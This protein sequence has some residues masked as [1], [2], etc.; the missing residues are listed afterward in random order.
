MTMSNLAR[1]VQIFSAPPATVTVSG[2]TLELREDQLAINVVSSGGQNVDVIHS[3][4]REGTQMLIR[5]TD[6]TNTVTLRDNQAGTNLSLGSTTRVLGAGDMIV[7]RYSGTKWEEVTFSA[8]AGNEDLFLNDSGSLT[9]GT[10]SDV[11]MAW[12]GTDFDITAAAD[13]SIIKLGTGT[14]S[15]DLWL[16]GNIA[17]S[18]LLWDASQNTVS[19]NGPVR[20]NGFNAL[21]RRF[22]LKW[23]AGQ[24]GKPGIN[25]DIQSATEAT[26]MI[27]DPDFEVLG[28]NASS[29]DVTF[30]AEGGIKVE[31]DGADGDEVIIAPHL[32][33]NQ[34]AWTQ[35][36]WGTDKQVV[37]E[38]HIKSGSAI[39]NCI[40]WAGLKLTNTEVTATDDDQAFF[41][42]ENGVNSGKWQAISSIGGTDDAADTGVTALADTEYHLKI[43]IGTD[44]TAQFY[45]NGALVETSAALTDATDLIPYIGIATD[46]A[47][48]AKHMY[49]FGQSIGRAIG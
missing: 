6:D 1:A 15:F 21:P 43:V 14:N 44:R 17:T 5:G 31:T 13:D 49:I 33:A 19:T 35:V 10:G 34:T 11:V 22:E 8:L 20:V 39:T 7:L 30:Y 23:V 48:E 24:R 3:N 37:W 16:Y 36:T 29:D 38:C 32:D 9:F 18:Y 28:T 41:R 46:G 12:D 26:R 47:A 25:G 42:Y 2:T 4:D 45:L 40:I 27:A